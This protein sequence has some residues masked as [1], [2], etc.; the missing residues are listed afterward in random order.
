L[1]TPESTTNSHKHPKKKKGRAEQIEGHAVKRQ[2]AWNI[3]LSLWA[4][5]MG[6]VNTVAVHATEN[7]LLYLAAN[8]LK[9]RMHSVR[10][11]YE[12]TGLYQLPKFHKRL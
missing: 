6:P 4:H 10:T 1:S 3:V 8:S 11:D 12:H 2:E 5:Y 7:F 9:T